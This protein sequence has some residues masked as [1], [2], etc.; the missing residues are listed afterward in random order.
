MKWIT[1]LA[2]VAVVG[3]AAV[4]AVRRVVAV[5]SYGRIPTSLR[6]ARL[7]E[8]L[9]VTVNIAPAEV[10]GEGGRLPEPLR[11]LGEAVEVQI[12]PA[13]GDRG[14][15]LRARP[16]AP[17]GHKAGP[18]AWRGLRLAL[19]HSKQLLDTGEILHA[20]QPSTTRETLTSSPLAYAVRHAR[21][22]GRL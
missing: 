8:W 5:R 15:E 1:R 17:E 18:E 13:P 4:Y 6:H 11:R 7:P 22:E 19:R 2:A 9:V 16:R 20:D 10:T 3:A 21:E 14:A 12:R